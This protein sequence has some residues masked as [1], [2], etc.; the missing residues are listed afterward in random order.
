MP[1]WCMPRLGTRM[2]TC[3]QKNGS[4]IPCAKTGRLERNF[5]RLMSHLANIAKKLGG[6]NRR[7]PLPTE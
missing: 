5:E 6:D 3:G 7:F 4:I 1:D 2:R